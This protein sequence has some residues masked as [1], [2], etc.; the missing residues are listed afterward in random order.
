MSDGVCCGAFA[1]LFISLP[2]VKQGWFRQIYLALRCIIAVFCYHLARVLKFYP[3]PKCG[4]SQKPRDGHVPLSI[5]DNR[6]LQMGG[7]VVAG[8]L[9]I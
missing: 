7:A 4:L 8:S 9:C 2:R 3:K 5:A 6:Q 1:G